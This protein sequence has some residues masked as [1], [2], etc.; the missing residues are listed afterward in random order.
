[1]AEP[2]A[3]DN[4]KPGKNITDPKNLGADPNFPRHVHKYAAK[5]VIND[6]LVVTTPAELEQAVAD[7]WSMTP[8]LVDPDAPVEDAKGKKRGAAA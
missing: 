3:F 8:V 1:M 5:G 7:G 4:L 6:Y 2:I